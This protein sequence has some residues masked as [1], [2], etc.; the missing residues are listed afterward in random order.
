MA[1]ILQMNSWGAPGSKWLGCSLGIRSL[2][3][4]LTA[5]RMLSSRRRPDARSAARDLLAQQLE[6]QPSLLRRAQLL[7]RS[8]ERRRRLVERL[9]VAGVETGIVE[10]LV[11]PAYLGLQLEHGLGQRFERMLLMEAQLAVRRPRRDR[12]RFRRRCFFRW[13]RRRLDRLA[14][15]ILAALRQ[16]VAVAAGV[17]DEAPAALGNDHS[18]DHAIEEVTIVADQQDGAG[19]VAEHFLQH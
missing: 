18:V 4:P 5:A 10:L 13:F 9:A 11:Q 3:R 7:L 2:A 8:G 16:H 14:R 17:F 1:R 12:R 19:I 15:Q 6:L